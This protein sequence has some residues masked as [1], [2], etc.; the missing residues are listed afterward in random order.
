MIL[1]DTSVW[2]D[3]LGP[4]PHH[5]LPAERIP[6]LA[7]TGPVLQEVLQGIR[8]DLAHARVRTSLMALTWIGDPLRSDYFDDA[9]ALYRLA[10]RRGLTVRSATDALIAAIAIRH[11]AAVWHQDRD[12]DALAR[13]SPL[14]VVRSLG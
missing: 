2:V 7:I 13:V 11:T 8:E 9:S 6:E 12:F 10:R 3:L 4:R 5:T 1:V 14:K